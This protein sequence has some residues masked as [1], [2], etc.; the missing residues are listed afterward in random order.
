MMLV[1]FNVKSSKELTLVKNFYSRY[2]D[3]PGLFDVN[4]HPRPD[5]EYF[6]IYNSPT[7]EVL[8]I[9][10]VT[11]IS[12]KLAK[13]QGTIVAKN[14]RG[15]GLSK[16][17]WTGVEVIMKEAGFEKAKCEVYY[18]NIPQLVARLKLGFLIEGLMRDHEEVGK[19]EYILGKR[20]V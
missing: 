1:R 9:T 8:A 3:E 6:G 7:N 19:H 4:S 10:A 20:L 17:L 18:D 5:T 14:Y 11:K 16:R 13:L 15:H 2:K 12:P